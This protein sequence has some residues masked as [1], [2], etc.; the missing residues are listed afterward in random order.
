MSYFRDSAWTLDPRTDEYYLHTFSSHQPK[1]N[2]WNPKVQQEFTDIL[3]FW[4]SR[5]VAG[6]RIDALQT[7]TR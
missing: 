2:W 4:F 5:G 3:H 1:L 6:V 7:L